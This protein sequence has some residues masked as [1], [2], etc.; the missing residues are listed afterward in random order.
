MR[1]YQWKRMNSHFSSPWRWQALQRSFGI[2]GAMILGLIAS[3]AIHAETKVATEPVVSPKF[4]AGT[5]IPARHGVV[6]NGEPMSVR[7]I[8]DTA[9]GGLPVGVVI[10]PET[11]RFNSHVQWS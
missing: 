10:A 8:A 7:T 6:V 3:L 9:Q 4:V 2:A 11:W 1:L 5:N